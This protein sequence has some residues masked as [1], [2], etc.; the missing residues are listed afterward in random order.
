MCPNR[1]ENREEELLREPAGFG[2]YEQLD[3]IDLMDLRSFLLLTL[4]WTLTLF[5]Q[6]HYFQCIPVYSIIV[7]DTTVSVY[8]CI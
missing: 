8:L 2:I 3:H 6:G 5:I 4:A 1:T 7:R